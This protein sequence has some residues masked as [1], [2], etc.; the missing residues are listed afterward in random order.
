MFSSLKNKRFEFLC[1]ISFFLVLGLLGYIF[2]IAG[3]TQKMAKGVHLPVIFQTGEGLRVGIEVRDR[4]VEAGVLSSM[5][6]V[7]LDKN[8]RPVTDL[9]FSELSNLELS[10]YRQAVLGILDLNSDVKLYANAE[11]KTVYV[12]ILGKRLISLYGG[13][14]KPGEPD[15]Y[16]L[17]LNLTQ[18]ENF[19][20]SG[21]FPNE[22]KNILTGY[23][24]NEP[25]TLLSDF[26]RENRKSILALTENLS[27]ITDKIN[28]GRG[29]LAKVL[30]N[31]SLYKNADSLLA[32]MDA[33]V[34]EL[35]VL[36]ESDR[37]TTA[38]VDTILMFLSF[39]GF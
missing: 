32:N 20:K 5:H 28:T 15:N 36:A 31:P 9:N 7:Y 27:S 39:G 3:K 2:I 18:L 23:N 30:N 4:G 34:K 17:T 16:Y 35:R 33:L 26:I 37:E 21:I 25:V 8:N 6:Y 22:N 29:D 19:K 11:A 38:I 14:K 1:G 12:N 24:F 13:Q 10:E